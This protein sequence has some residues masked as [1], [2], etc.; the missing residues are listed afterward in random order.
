M[1]ASYLDNPGTLKIDLMLRGIRLPE[2]V[3]EL[4]FYGRA[5]EGVDL[6]LPGGYPV[7]VPCGEEFTKDSPYEL[8][9]KDGRWFISD[10]SD[11]VEVRP[12]K[13]PEF[14]SRTTSE[15]TPYSEIA[16]VHGSYVL[17]LPKR[18]C[19]F[20][21]KKVECSYC[22]GGYDDGGGKTH[23]VD[24]VV[25][26][27][28]AVLEEGVS[29]IIY[30]S[31][32][33]TEDED[34]GIGF[35]MPYLEAVKKRFNCLVAVEALPPKS[36]HWIDQTYAAGADALLYNLEIYDEEL[37]E[38]L[39]PGRARFIGRRRYLE[40]LRYAA[41]IFPNGTVASHLIVGLEPPGSTC[42]GIDAL[43][44]MG[45]VPILPIYR[46]RPGGALRIEPLNAEVI[47][48][49]Y[50]HLYRAV[51]RRGINMNWMRDISIVTTPIE[52]RLLTGEKSGGL[53]G[54]IERFYGTRLGLKAAWG[55]STI[56]RKLRV[57]E[58]E[59]ED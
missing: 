44:E 37:F 32:G 17:V 39:C 38:A 48:P 41:E 51:K 23:R 49:I 43:T 52:G 31:T 56:R 8:C 35:L 22:A 12:V 36:N 24:E 55:L 11:S 19:V 5:G 57:K 30:L 15:G 1:K 26:V 10:G 4:C 18:E 2:G 7:N 14:L 21:E 25:E 40:A 13:R 54:L 29:E 53:S 59:D 16:K 27:V 46:P 50:R 45:V 28:A 34:G 47:I 42:M 3:E 6:I 58:I 9:Q 20:F 33:F